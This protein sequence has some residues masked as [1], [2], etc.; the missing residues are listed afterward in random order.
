[1]FAKSYPLEEMIETFDPIWGEDEGVFL[2]WA[3]LIDEHS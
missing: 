1:M 3:V 2:Y